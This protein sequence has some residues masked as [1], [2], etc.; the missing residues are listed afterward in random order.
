[1]TKKQIAEFLEYISQKVMRGI[2]VVATTHGRRMHEDDALCMA[3]IRAR[4]PGIKLRVIRSR[5]PEDWARA[6]FVLDVGRQDACDGHSLWLDHHQC[7]EYWSNGVRKAACGKL[8]EVFW[9]DD[10]EFLV[11]LR[12]ILLNSVEA[13]D[14]G[15]NLSDL[16]LESS[17]TF[18]VHGFNPVAMAGEPC[19]DAAYD[20]DFEVVSP[21][22]DVVLQRAI[23][24][25]RAAI[26]SREA[27]EKAVSEYDCNGLLVIPAPVSDAWEP[28]VA[29]LNTTLQDSEKVLFVCILDDDLTA[30]DLWTVKKEYPKFGALFDLPESWGGLSDDELSLASGVDG[31]IFCPQGRY[32]AV[33]KKFASAVEA[34]RKAVELVR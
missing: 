2:E 12:R 31:A 18:F 34:G 28:A 33:W 25:A 17:R 10:P 11:E 20:A 13:I 22:V 9:G 30:G 8:A 23:V 27:V 15:Q 19:T 7:E 14:N 5:N 16:G 1:M 6:D 21:M 29:A 4:F 32:L 3:E 26:A 24:E